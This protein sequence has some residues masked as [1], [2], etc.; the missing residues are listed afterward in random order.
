M[1]DSLLM[2][3][4]RGEQ[5]E[6][7]VRT[8]E[9]TPAEK[10]ATASKEEEKRR[11]EIIERVRQRLFAEAGMDLLSRRD[12]EAKQRLTA[13]IAELVEQEGGEYPRLK[14]AAL[15][16]DLAADVWGY[17]PIQ[18]LIDDDSVSEIM[19]NRWDQVYIERGGKLVK[20]D[21][22]FRNDDHVKNVIQKIVGPIGRRIDES[23]PL[24][25]ARLPDGSRVNAVIPPLAIDGSNITIRKFGK[26]LSIED[27]IRFGTATEREFKFLEATVRGKLNILISGGTGSGKTTLLNVLSSFIPSSERIITIEDAAELRLQQEHVVRLEARPANIEGKGEIPIR[28]LVKNAL[29]MRPDRIIV[30]ECRGGEALDMLQAMNTGHEGSMTTLHANSPRDAVSRLEVMVLLAGEELP[31]RAIREQVASAI[32]MIVQ[33]SRL[34]DGS[35]R[36]THISEV[37]G[38]TPDGNVDVRDVFR[39]EI[40]GE[41]NDRIKGSLVMTGYKPAF[42][43]KLAWQGIKLDDF[44]PEGMETN[45]SEIG[46]S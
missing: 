13:L 30:G 22:Q 34:R 20:A 17:G 35:R 29:R 8:V 18:S 27:L 40:T 42:L 31:H 9:K 44:W 14:R 45:G 43:K 6:G 1:A 24:V 21:I 7:P 10:M 2:R 32:D 46:G 16:K 37:V 28:M 19:V 12:P 4:L 26:R 5:G 33:I 41:E 39:L 11:D 36:I 23:M 3:R 15:V 25:D 38:L